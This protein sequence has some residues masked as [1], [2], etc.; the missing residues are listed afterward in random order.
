MSVYTQRPLVWE[1]RYDSH[2]LLLDHIRGLGSLGTLSDVEF[3]VV[4]LGQGLKAVTLNRR[5][6][7]EH[8][9]T[10]VLL[11][12]AKAFRVVEP[13][14]C[15]YCQLHSP[16]FHIEISVLHRINKNGKDP[17]VPNPC[18]I[19]F[20]FD[21]TETETTFFINVPTYTIISQKSSSFFKL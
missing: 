17:E 4:T 19:V 9:L 5:K 3:D 6:M 16:P 2:K 15:A 8:V 11:D 10:C 21:C 14:H 7:N 1:N 20:L 18:R 12:E 13:L